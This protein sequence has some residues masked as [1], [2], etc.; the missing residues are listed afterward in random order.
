LSDKVGLSG[1]IPDGIHFFDHLQELSLTRDAIT[2]PLPTNS[3]AQALNL[4]RLNL[5]NQPIGTSFV[6]AWE[7]CKS[8]SS[9]NFDYTSL[10]GPVE[11]PQSPN[12]IERFSANGNGI[13]GTLSPTIG[14]ATNLKSLSLNWNALSGSIPSELYT[15]SNLEVLSLSSNTIVGTIGTEIGGMQSLQTYNL[16]GNILS[17]QLA[18]F[19]ESLRELNLMDNGGMDSSGLN[20]T[21]SSSFP[22]NLESLMM[23]GNT[24]SGSIPDSIFSLTR[25]RELALGSNQLNGTISTR[26]GQLTALT[27]LRL[28]DNSFTSTIPA[29][30]EA[31]TQLNL[32]D[33]SQNSFTGVLEFC[34]AENL[35]SDCLPDTNNFTAVDCPCCSWC[36]NS[37]SICYGQHI[38]D[39]L[40]TTDESGISCY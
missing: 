31:L 36:C 11:I 12:L 16:F 7:A 25:L 3:L 39:P 38:D 6:D 2:G 17:G 22:Q 13:T 4:V 35:G 26:I 29:E 32:A 21:L 24:F 37:T 8:I 34:A 18:P 9:V 5:A 23:S 10:V 19:P 1:A 20:G 33:F 15:L 14:R 30:V 27:Y 28:D 40:C